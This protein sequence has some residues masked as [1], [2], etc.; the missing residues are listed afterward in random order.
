MK[1]KEFKKHIQQDEIAS[2]Y[3]FTG[4]EK[5]LIDLAYKTLEKKLIDPNFKSLNVTVFHDKDFDL[6]KFQDAVETLPFMAEK[7]LVVVKE[8]LFLGTQKKGAS[9]EEEEQV[10][11]CISNLPKQVCVVF[12]CSKVDARKKLVKTIK[13]EGEHYQFDSLQESELLRWIKGKIN[14][15]KIEVEAAALNY[16]VANMDYLGRNQKK[17]L[18]DVENEVNKLIHYTKNKGRVTQQDIDQITSKSFENDI[19]KVMDA[20]EKKNRREGLRRIDELIQQGEPVLKILATLSNQMKNV[21]KVKELSAKGY[22][23]KAIAKR[24]G[25]HP[26]VATKSLKQ[27]RNYTE[28]Q[29]IGFI[30]Y[31]TDIDAKIKSGQIQDLL[32]IELIV[33]ELCK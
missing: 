22:T 4:A 19:F 32:G 11:Q 2:L 7:R 29:L 17:N 12:L 25:I 3:L 8:P 26:F 6:A 31:I 16:F 1:W 10:L 30:N 23:S 21:L 5:Y 33:L 14:K 20:I 24:I 28:K 15:E 18:F 9:K 13:K 27:S